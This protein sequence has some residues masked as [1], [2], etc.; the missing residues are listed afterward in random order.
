MAVASPPELRRICLIRLSS[1]GDVCHAAAVVQAIQRHYPEARVT[2]VVGGTEAALIGDLPAVEFV[3]YDK[4]RGLAGLAEVRRALSRRR[5]DALLHMQVSLRASLVSLLVRAPLKIGFDR[6]RAAEGQWLFTN[7]AVAAQPR[8]HVLDGFKAFAAAISV[9]DFSPSW[10]IPVSADDREWAES[11]LPRGRPVLGIVPAAS[12]PERNWTVEGYAAVAAHALDRGFRVALY[13]GGSPVEQ[14]LGEEI[15]ERLGRPVADLI[16]RTTL[17]QLLALMGR[18]GLLLAP[19]TG[20]AHM[21]VTQGVPVIGLYCHSNPLRTGP[22]TCLDYVVSHYEALF[23]QRYG[24]GWED[25]PWGTRIKGRRLMETIRPEEV[26]SMFD[27]VV[28]ER[29]ILG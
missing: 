20:P 25:R 13:G 14:T 16:G 4:T 17:K 8:A 29:R 26:I 11:V 5:F 15:R 6:A 12:R 19:D 10:D 22:Y 27:R 23:R 21:A 9:P 2:W 7:R 18:T 1:I 3:V 28:A 24:V